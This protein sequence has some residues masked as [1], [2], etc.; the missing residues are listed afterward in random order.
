MKW[1]PLHIVM[2]MI[3]VDAAP[4]MTFR[5]RLGRAGKATDSPKMR[6]E[7]AAQEA[8]GKT[9]KAVGKA[10]DAVKGAVDRL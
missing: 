10:K 6:A 3:A 4:A 5:R 1:A 9:Q 7:G 8:K 2:L